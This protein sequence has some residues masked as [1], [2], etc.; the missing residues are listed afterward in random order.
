MAWVATK[1]C[2]A[3]AGAW[4]NAGHFSKRASQAEVTRSL[5]SSAFEDLGPFRLLD[6]AGF[7]ALHV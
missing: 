2:L 6:L 1:E 7:V 3:E 5:L 4:W